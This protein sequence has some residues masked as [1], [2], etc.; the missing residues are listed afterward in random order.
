MPFLPAHG[1]LFI[2]LI[3]LRSFAIPLPSPFPL[4]VFAFACVFN[5]PRVCFLHVISEVIRNPTFVRLQV[6]LDDC[7]QLVTVTFELLRVH[8]QPVSELGWCFAQRKA[9]FHSI[10]Q[11]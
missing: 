11:L 6:G 7:S 3:G 1:A 2:L 5:F 9:V 10:I 8:Q 4:L